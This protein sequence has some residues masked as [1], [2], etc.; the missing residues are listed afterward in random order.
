MV[1]CYQYF[2]RYEMRANHNCWQIKG[3][4]DRV[5]INIFKDT[6]WEQITTRKPV[7]T[8]SLRCYQYFQRYEMR[9]NHNRSQSMQ[10][11]IIVVI[12][13]FKDT[14]WEQITTKTYMDYFGYKLL[15]IFSKIRNESKSQPL[16][17]I[18]FGLLSCYQYFQRYE[19]R[20]NHNCVVKG[21]S[22]R[23]LLSIFSKIRNESKSQLWDRQRLKI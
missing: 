17:C 7:L 4:L 1:C 6:K 20:A 19:M 21:F 12:N 23:S 8:H 18:R 13:I 9:A 2:Q 22:H 11:K 3:I 14:K 15:S 5:V 16:P 10:L